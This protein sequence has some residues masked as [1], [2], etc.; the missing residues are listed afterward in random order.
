MS[1]NAPGGAAMAANVITYRG[2]SVAREVGKALGF[3]PESLQRLSSLVASNEWKA[4]MT[5]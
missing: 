1:I 4:R 3:D 2:K 5:R